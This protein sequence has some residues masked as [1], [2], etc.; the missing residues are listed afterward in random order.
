MHQLLV[1]LQRFGTLQQFGAGL[2]SEVR[3][4]GEISVLFIWAGIDFE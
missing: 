1:E 3:L 4:L 2:T